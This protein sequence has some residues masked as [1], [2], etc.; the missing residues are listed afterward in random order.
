M[1]YEFDAEFLKR[2]IE[3]MQSSLYITDPVTHEILYTNGYIK[4]AFNCEMPEGKYCWEILQKDMKEPCPFCKIPALADKELGEAIVWREHNEASGRDYINYDWLEEWNGRRYHIQN[5]VDITSFLQLSIEA[6]I[7]ELT[8]LLNRNAGKNHLSEV[9]SSL[10]EDGL[11][12]VALCDLNGL[13]WVNDTYG[14]L[15]GDRF[16]KVTA[17]TMQ[18]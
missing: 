16:L 17:C 5:S 1:D 3:R 12:T 6:S 4:E 11:C 18:E 8:G 7:D 10:K 15:E 2:I 9:L 14:H 13:K